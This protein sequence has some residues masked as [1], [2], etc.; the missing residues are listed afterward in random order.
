[1]PVIP[2]STGTNN[3]FPS[4]VEGT[5][6]GLAAGLVASGA[7]SLENVARVSKTVTVRIEEEEDDLALIDAALLDGAFLGSRAIWS[8]NVLRTF[9]LTRADPAGVGLTSIGGLVHPVG[10][11]EDAGLLIR[12]GDGEGTVTA[13]VAPGLMEPV[14]L[15][16]VDTMAMGD[17][18]DVTGPGVLAFD[19][20]RE[21]RLKPGQ[22]S[23]LTLGRNGPHLIDVQKTMHIAA[24]EG[25]LRNVEVPHGD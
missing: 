21:R 1:M 11:D 3:V 22:R 8:A 9:V 23:T 25:L 19:G 6:A 14:P 20:E 5:A 17:T 4:M 2:I 18:I 13:P 24:C 10:V 7:V 16:Q 15:A 12:C